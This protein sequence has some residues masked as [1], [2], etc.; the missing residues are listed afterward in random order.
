VF[1]PKNYTL[2][3]PER[4]PTLFTIHGGGFVIGTPDDTDPWN[5]RFAS[6]H[7]VLV[8]ALNYRK[9]PRYPFPTA[10]YDVEALI[11]AILDDKTLPIDL[12][13]VAI[14]GWS[15]G[16]NLSLTVSQ[17]PSMRNPDGSFRLK[18]VL[19]IYPVVDVSVPDSELVKCRR[20]K[21]D[22]GGFR[23][24]PTD[25]LLPMSPLFLWA[26]IPP[27]Q[28]LRDP[29]LSPRYADREVLPKQIFAIACELDMLSHPAWE[30]MSN[31]A[32]RDTPG[33]VVG[34]QETAIGGSL[35]LNDPNFHFE[36]KLE[37]GSCYKWL[38][39]PDTIHGFD[40]PLDGLVREEGLLRDMEVRKELTMKMIADWLFEGAFAK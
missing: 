33:R 3:C 9:A 40:M 37:D 7:S 26:F 5:H 19:P 2:A 21:P 8:I 34:R 27:G 18:A 17:L 14:A 16:G 36:E 29:L 39:V 12:D 32:R 30:M 15:A 28:D 1:L 22:L 6:D 38:L 10:V 11:T 4:F 24:R 25:Y 13:R 35:I 23:G 20:Y 31:F